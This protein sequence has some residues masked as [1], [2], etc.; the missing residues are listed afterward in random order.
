MSPQSTQVEMSPIPSNWGMDGA[1]VRR[2]PTPLGRVSLHHSW[3][4]GGRVVMVTLCCTGVLVVKLVV[5][6]VELVEEAEREGEDVARMVVE[7]GTGSDAAEV[8][9]GEGA[10]VGVGLLEAEASCS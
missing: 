6:V 1:R 7:W 5:E 2:T 10:G 4:A 8:G 3:G 9:G